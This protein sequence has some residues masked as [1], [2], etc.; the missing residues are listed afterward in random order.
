MFYRNAIFFSQGFYCGI[1]MKCYCNFVL[2]KFSPNYIF[3]WVYKLLNV[4]TYTVI[5]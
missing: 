5:S 1:N 4:V 3:V 2:L